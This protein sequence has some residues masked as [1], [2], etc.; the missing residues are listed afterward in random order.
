M[1]KEQII[2]QLEKV[3]DEKYLQYVYELLLVFNE[4]KGE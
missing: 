3:T 4:D 1:M 2:A